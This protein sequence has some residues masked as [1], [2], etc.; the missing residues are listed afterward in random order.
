MNISEHK[1][2]IFREIDQLPEESLLELEN[3]IKQIRDSKKN[4][5]KRQFG[6]MKGLLVSMS[7]DF[8]APLADFHEYM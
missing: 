4:I 5:K 3:I 8:D 6:C 1:L 7:D 2:N